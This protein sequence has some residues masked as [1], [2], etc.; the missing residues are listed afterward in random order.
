MKKIISVILCFVLVL[1]LSVYSFGATPVNTSGNVVITNWPSYFTGQWDLTISHDVAMILSAVDSFSG[2]IPEIETDVNEISGQLVLLRDYLQS[3]LTNTGLW[4][5]RIETL[6][7]NFDTYFREDFNTS[8]D[9]NFG[10]VISSVNSVRSAVSTFESHLLA[11][12]QYN[13]ADYQT[14]GTFGHLVFMLQQVLADDDD[15]AMKNKNKQQTSDAL[16]FA[17]TGVNIGNGSNLNFFNTVSTGVS[18]INWFTDFFSLDYD[19]GQTLEY[20]STGFS[21]PD[22][23]IWFTEN[24]K[25]DING[26]TV[27]SLSYRSENEI[28][29]HYYQDNLNKLNL[30]LG[31]DLK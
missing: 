26:S 7:T 11:D 23:W 10:G 16:Q 5:T 27:S 22:P 2:S 15:L 3:V 29:T 6:L 17:E 4:Q 30:L 25:N 14:T 18:G 21:F 13:F 24:N 1:S 9:N 31:G 28:V 20:I 12:I 8:L 19:F